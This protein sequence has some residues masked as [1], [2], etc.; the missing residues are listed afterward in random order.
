M[1]HAN[2]SL[3]PRPAGCGWPS[4][5][6]DKGWPLRRA[7]ER[8]NCAVTTARRWADRYRAAGPR[9]G[10]STGPRGP[11]RCPGQTPTRVE[12]RVVGLRVTRR[13]GPARIAYRLRHEPLDGA[14]DPAP[15]RLPAA[16]VDRPGHRGP[17]RDLGR[18]TSAA[19]STPH[20]ATWSTSTSR[21][22][23]GSPTAAAGAVA[24][25]RQRRRAQG[26]RPAPRARGYAYIHHAV[27]DHSRLAYTEILADERRRP[28]PGSGAAPERLL[29][30][31]RHHRQRGAD[32]QRLLL[33]L[34]ALRPRPSA[35]RSSTAH[36][37]LPAPDQRQGR[38]VQPHPA[39]GMGLRPRLPLRSRTR[40]R[41]PR[42]APHLQSPPR[43]HR[44]Q[45]QVT[46]RPRAQPPWTEHLRRRVRADGAGPR[47]QRPHCPTG[48]LDA[49]TRGRTRLSGGARTCSL[50]ADAAVVDYSSLR[51]D[52]G[53]TGKPMV[54]HV[55]DLERYREMW[56]GWLFDFEPTAPGPL[57]AT[58]DEVVRHFSLDLDGLRAGV[59]R[60]V[61]VLPR[62]T[63]STWRT[64]RPDA[65]SSTP[66]SH[67]AAT[68]ETR[69]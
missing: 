23:A 68:P 34:Q 6:V 46:S 65:G 51:F 15:L 67:R 45:G 18:P 30:R 3:T 55:P 21:S 57:V 38:T 10:W 36:P 42:L 27:D 37:A 40:S 63:T 2:A 35:A 9:P 47:V 50:A 7:A 52:F 13:W 16:D 29:R 60:G 56:C 59:R 48:R 26:A 5:V 33:P 54:F 1:S 12:R 4:C 39:R 8:F 66:S 11:H 62:V 22:S 41:L 25:G 28:P 61:R 58:T 44:T 20:P 49:R 31:P 24:L 14:Q 32:R 43:P 53:V 19:T 64:D 69:C 17:D